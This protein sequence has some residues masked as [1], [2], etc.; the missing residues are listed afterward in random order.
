MD[1][2][3]QNKLNKCMQKKFILENRSLNVFGRFDPGDL[4][5]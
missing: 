3:V 1:W 2:S 4:D 5:L